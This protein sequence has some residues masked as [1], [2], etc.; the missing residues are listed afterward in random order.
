[1]NIDVACLTKYLQI[2]FSNI[3]DN[4][5]PYPSGEYSMGATV[6]HYSKINQFNPPYSQTKEK[7]LCDYIS[8]EKPFDKIEY[9]PRTSE[10]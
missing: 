2:E 7:K 1:M 9:L 8:T 6:F 4:Y 3:L 5:K 10:N